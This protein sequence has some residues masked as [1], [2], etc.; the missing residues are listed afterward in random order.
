MVRLKSEVCANPKWEK[1]RT[2]NGMGLAVLT[3]K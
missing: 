3:K 2:A 1:V